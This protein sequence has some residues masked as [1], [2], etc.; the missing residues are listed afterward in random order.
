HMADVV[1]QPGDI[2]VIRTSVAELLSMKEEGDLTVP[3][4][5]HMQSLGARDSAVVE[6]LIG[7]GAG[8][9]GKT[10]RHLRLRR[11]YGVYPVALGRRVSRLAER[12]DTAPLEVGDTLLVE[13]SPDDLQRRF[14]DY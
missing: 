11:R 3:E 7:P 6:I 4:T 9:L 1:L 2:V 14:E 5:E 13:G 10:L 12:F 8:V